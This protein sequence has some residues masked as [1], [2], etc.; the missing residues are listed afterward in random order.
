MPVD[1]NYASFLA[2]AKYVL[3]VELKQPLLAPYNYCIRFFTW[4]LSYKLWL[5]Y[6]SDAPIG[7]LH[8]FLF[9]FSLGFM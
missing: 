8:F 6:Y 9:V 1:N 3:S 5:D 4:F 2:L 7:F